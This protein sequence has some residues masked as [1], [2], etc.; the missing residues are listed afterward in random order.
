MLQKA[1][2]MIGCRMDAVAT[3]KNVINSTLGIHT[4]TDTETKGELFPFILLGLRSVTATKE[5]RFYLNIKL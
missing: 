1:K 4:H 3:G 5:Q 2:H